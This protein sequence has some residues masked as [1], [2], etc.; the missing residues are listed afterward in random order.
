MRIV[1][2]AAAL[3]LACFAFAPTPAHAET[4]ECPLSTARRNIVNTLPSGWYTTPVQN[5]LMATRVVNIGRQPTMS[6]DY[7]EVGSVMREVPA[8]QTCVARTGGFECASSSGPTPMPTSE[9]HR[10]GTFNVRGTYDFDLDAG[11]EATRATSDFWYEVIRAGETYFTPRNGAR[12]ASFGAREPSYAD[13]AAATLTNTRTRIETLG[14][15]AAWL[16][17]RTSE[18]RL[19]RL[20]IDGVNRFVSPQVMTITFATWR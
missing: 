19:A 5:R 3:T 6:C 10:T 12:L 7:G 15:G 8:G 16:C 14:A 17:V 2:A 11:A 1:F 18:G 9:T 20:H 13:C 4:Y